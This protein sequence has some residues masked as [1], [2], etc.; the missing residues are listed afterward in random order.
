VEN[1]KVENFAKGGITETRV[2]AIDPYD[3]YGIKR[4]AK[5]QKDDIDYIKKLSDDEFMNQAEKQGY[6]W[7]SWDSFIDSN[8]FNDDEW[9]K[10]I[11]HREIKV[12]N[13]HYAKGGEID[14]ESMSKQE[15]V[16]RF[17]D[18][19]SADLDKMTDKEVIDEYK[20]WFEVWDVFE[21]EDSH[22]SISKLKQEL[23]E[24]EERWKWDY[25][26]DE[27]IDVH[28]GYD[29]YAKG[30]F[31]SIREKLAN[32]SIEDLRTYRD[33]NEG[34][35]HDLLEGRDNSE[36][37]EER[38]E[39]DRE[40][41]KN[42]LVYQLLQREFKNRGV[43]FFSNNPLYAKGGKSKDYS[44]DYADIGQFSMDR[45]AWSDFT[46]KQFE[47]IGKDIVEV[48]YDGNIEKA[49]E[50]IVR[51]KF[52]GSYAKGGKIREYGVDVDTIHDQYRDDLQ[53]DTYEK[54]LKVYKEII[55][56]DT[57][58][59]EQLD[60]VQLVEVYDY[61]FGEGDYS[62]LLS[63][64]YDIE[65]AKGGKTYGEISGW[66]EGV[67][68]EVAD[69][70]LE[71]EASP[72][73]A[74]KYATILQQPSDE[75][76][77]VM[78]QYENGTIDY[79]P[80][81]VINYEG[82]AKGGKTK[83]PFF[84]EKGDRDIVELGELAYISSPVTRY[85]E[86]YESDFN[87]DVHGWNSVRVGSLGNNIGYGGEDGWF[88]EELDRPISKQQEVAIN[89]E[90]EDGDGY[91]II[92][93]DYVKPLIDY[94]NPEGSYEGIKAKGGEVDN[95]NLQGDLQGRLMNYDEL[96]TIY[97]SEEEE[98][99]PQGYILT[100]GEESYFYYD[101]ETRDSDRIIASKVLESKYKAKYGR[102]YTVS[103]N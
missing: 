68:V 50:S 56:K 64:H 86:G 4:K 53:F 29:D 42:R 13:V 6:V 49:Y 18:K 65:Y 80:Q 59:N 77:L 31:V 39:Y 92:I 21:E 34:Q 48:D 90:D 79:V 73:E 97:V 82:Y 43:D 74:T 20:E 81:D 91:P 17:M 35:E 72:K 69:Y 33:N 1:I 101:A 60:N 61:D 30:G 66:V 95:G 55:S 24:D 76:E 84:Y 27:L 63:K 7:S 12:D 94:F 87:P 3:F 100:I 89:Y 54:A 93:V 47:K 36:I 41:Q 23:L 5:V 9:A 70:Y 51:Q 37:P 45:E 88:D 52:E 19:R 85:D 46:D 103:M 38:A 67:D 14:Y 8:E 98:L 25:A 26:K 22:K 83:E 10:K 78:I 15:L 28:E 44:Y 40:L 2:Y 58:N 62:T 99:M 16:D 57:Y 32:M 96:P 11:I 71:D 75:E 102:D